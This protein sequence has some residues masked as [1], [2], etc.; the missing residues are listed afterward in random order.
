MSHL[1]GSIGW[2]RKVGKGGGGTSSHSGIHFNIQMRFKTVKI[3]LRTEMNAAFP[4]PY[5]DG[6]RS[7][8]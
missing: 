1:D 7:T 5:L 4:V 8:R 2:M 6:R 3:G